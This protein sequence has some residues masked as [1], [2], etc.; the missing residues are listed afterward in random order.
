MNLFKLAAGATVFLLSSGLVAA[1]GEPS[2]YVCRFDAGT[3]AVYENGEFRDEV[4]N[5]VEFRLNA[6][7]AA[8]QSAT[9]VRNGGESSLR[10]VRAVNALH[11]L[12]V[13]GE[14][15][16][17]L[18]TV[19]DRDERTGRHPAIHSRHFGVLGQPVVSQY[20]GFCSGR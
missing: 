16:L 2:E 20:R 14:G 8:K 3:V 17:N 10:V 19:Y 4:V 9:V 12:E 7:D 13:A 5:P 11:F 6:I 15:F 1:A 18:T